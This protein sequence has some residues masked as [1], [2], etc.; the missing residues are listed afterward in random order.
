V[1]IVVDRDLCQGHAACEGEAP[2]VFSVSKKGDLTILQPE[3]PEERRR[4]V[5][6]AVKYCPTQALSIVDTEED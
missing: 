1:K 5:E 6:L 4:A 2:E 3:P